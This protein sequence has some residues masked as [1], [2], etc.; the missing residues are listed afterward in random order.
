MFD[1]KY[2][3]NI[4]NKGI[5]YKQFSYYFL[6]RINKKVSENHKIVNALVAPTA[7]ESR[8]ELHIDL[9]GYSD[10]LKFKDIKI[11]TFHLNTKEVLKSYLKA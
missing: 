2:F 3:G 10:I 7:T 5:E 6:L 4:E 1:A 11:L 9:T 8:A